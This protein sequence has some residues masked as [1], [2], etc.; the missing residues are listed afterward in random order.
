MKL[1]VDRCVLAAA[2][3]HACLTVALLARASRHMRQHGKW[4]HA[5]SLRCPGPDANVQR[6][7]CPTWPCSTRSLPRSQCNAM[8]T[9]RRFAYFEHDLSAMATASHSSSFARRR[10]STSRFLSSIVRV[11]RSSASCLATGAR[12][13]AKPAPPQD[14]PAARRAGAG[15]T[16]KL[17][18][19]LQTG[20]R[21][22]AARSALDCGAA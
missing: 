18:E 5:P 7:A 20:R 6:P 22:S 17:L 11:R 13:P 2:R 14:A 1:L 21:L 10:S 19:L 15:I 8:T 3:P 16:H 12:G 9:T 4:Q